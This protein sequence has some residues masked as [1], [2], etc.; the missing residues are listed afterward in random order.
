[1]GAIWVFF[2]IGMVVA[3]F[4]VPGIILHRYF[5]WKA[6]WI[7]IAVAGVL[8]LDHVLA[9]RGFEEA[10][11]RLPLGSMPEHQDP[12]PLLII[13][14]SHRCTQG[15]A[16]ALT[17]MEVPYVYELIR[18][19]EERMEYDAVPEDQAGW[20][21]YRVDDG[22]GACTPIPNDYNDQR[23]CV[24][25]ASAPTLSQRD[26]YQKSRRTERLGFFSSITYRYG[27]RVYEI[28]GE[29][30]FTTIGS[31]YCEGSTPYTDNFTLRN[32]LTMSIIWDTPY[33]NA[34]RLDS[35]YHYQ[36]END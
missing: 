2:V 12:P 36:P 26:L 8:V 14:S 20:Q 30:H 5:K 9:F 6:A 15:C 23:L 10:C 11:R 3:A 31:N 18:R 7:P 4:V 13:G 29:H 16:W 27:P 24:E 28:G 32:P 22:S 33:E 35:D 19:Y 17:D 34:F 25:L 1:M 21:R